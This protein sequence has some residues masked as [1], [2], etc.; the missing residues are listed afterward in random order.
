MAAW[1]AISRPSAGCS[2]RAG[3][4]A[5][6]SAVDEP[7]GRFLA[8]QLAEGPGDGRLDPRVG[9]QARR[10]GLGTSPPARDGSRNGARG[11]R[12]PRSTCAPMPGLPGAH[13][14]QN[15]A[16]AY[17]AVRALGLAPRV[18]RGRARLVQGPAPSQPAGGRDRRRVFRQRQQ[19]D[20]CGRRDQGALG[21]PAHP[22]DLWRAWPRKAGW[23]RLPAAAG[24]VVKA[25]V[26]GREAEGFA[27]GLGDV[28]QEI[29]GEMADPPSPRAA[30]EA[31]P[32]DT[33]LLAPA[34]GELRPVR[35][36]RETRR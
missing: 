31:E 7:E 12:S 19:G 4:I 21:L 27:L 1:A 26:I 23:R 11:G 6:S 24:N 3:R 30:A 33:V 8:N 36:F 35:Q 34:G 5:P 14:Q 25:Y 32:G 28:P 20:E 9:G 22:L 16:C 13:N 2:P 10:S 18:H 17:A 15:A 29:C